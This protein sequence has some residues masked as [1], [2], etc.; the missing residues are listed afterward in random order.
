ASLR[1]TPSPALRERVSSEARRARVT[2]VR[3]T[4]N[5][6][7]LRDGSLPLPHCGKGAFGSSCGRG[8][9]LAAHDGRRV[10]HGAHDL[11]VAG[12]AAG[13]AGE[14]IAR[15]FLGRVFVLVEERLRGDDEARRAEAALQRGVL[16][17]FLLDR[18]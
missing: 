10:E 17:E 12:A 15:L 16:E 14:P 7:S 9:V 5:L 8:R 11:V 4:L 3:M 2:A 1:Q 18:V 13:I 6:P